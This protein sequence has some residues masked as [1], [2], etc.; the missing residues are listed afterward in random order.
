MSVRVLVGDCRE[1][2]RT[3]EAGS[4]QTC[5]TSPPYFGLRSYSTNPQVWGGD[6]ACQHAWGGERLRPTGNNPSVKST[7][8][9]NNGRGPLPGDKFHADA[10]Q[11]ASSGTTCLRCTA[12]RGEL[13]SE[14]TPEQYIANLVDVFR[15]VRRV[16]RDDGTCWVNLGSSYAGSGK[17]P[18]N[19]APRPQ[20]SLNNRQLPAGAAPSVWQGVA[21]GFK[22]KDLMMM[23]FF[24]AEALR[25]DGWWLRS[26]ITWCKR[27]PMPE[28]VT[29]R[30]TSATEMIFLFS[31]SARYYY[32]ADAVREPNTINPAWNYGSERYRR[33]M[34]QDE[35][36]TD[37]DFRCPKSSGPGWKGMAPAG[38]DGNGR[39]LWN[40]WLLEES[41]ERLSPEWTEA[42]RTYAESALRDFWAQ[43]LEEQPQAPMAPWWLLSPEPYPNAHFATFVTE[44]PRRAILAGT[45]ERGACPACGAGW[46]RVVEKGALVSSDGRTGSCGVANQ[47]GK[48]NSVSRTKSA[49]GAE[50]SY[51]AMAR[52]ERKAIDW[53]PSCRCDAGEP[54]PCVVLDPFGGSGTTG[55][56]ADR[57]GRDAILIELNPEYAEMARQRII[58]DAPLLA[59]SPAIPREEIADKQGQLGKHN[60]TG[61]NARWDAAEQLR[62]DERPA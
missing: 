54:R 60:Y 39:N 23:P 45:S 40:Y 5:V 15:E 30:P 38:P 12:W 36:K 1:V 29:D 2:L 22:P 8:T 56:V 25:Q 35:I 4:V 7:L 31:K 42:Q 44:I 57:L 49:L 16:L 19:D 51:Y 26:A 11:T 9:T 41:Y 21:P 24:V 47:E 13:G 34:S 28:S 55:L 58:N 48:G 46:I 32:D 53:Q 43:L 10:G 50:Q 52:R 14:N 17:G 6:S 61:F 37:G 20:A 62:M 27:A 3:P 59:G 18:S 33:N